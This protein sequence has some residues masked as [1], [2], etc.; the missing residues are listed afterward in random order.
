MRAARRARRAWRTRARRALRAL[1][2]RRCGRERGRGVFER[3]D[4]AAAA[5]PLGAPV[6]VPALV[7]LRR[8]GPGRPRVVRAQ[9]VPPAARDAAACARPERRRAPRLHGAQPNP[10]TLTLNL[11]PEPKHLTLTLTLTLIPTPTPTPPQPQPQPQPQPHPYPR[12]QVH[13]ALPAAVQPRPPSPASC[14]T[15]RATCSACTGGCKRAR[16]AHAPRCAPR[17]AACCSPR[18]RRSCLVTSAP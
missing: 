3:G 17:A 5:A 1:R 7:P 2:G 11:T 12:P 14:P 16:R 18:S 6:H 9:H 15:S 8:R 4:A 10:N 13:S